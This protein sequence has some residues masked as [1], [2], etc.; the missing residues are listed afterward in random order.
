MVQRR[1]FLGLS[2]GVLSACAGRP[3]Y[4]TSRATY[5]RD[6]AMIIDAVTDATVSLAIVSADRSLLFAQR[7]AASAPAASVAKIAI[8][9]AAIDNEVDFAE[10]LDRT[11]RITDDMIVPSDVLLGSTR[12]QHN[13]ATLLYDMIVM[14]DNLAANALI[15]FIG[16][17]N[18]QN[19]LARRALRSTQ[20]TGYYSVRDSAAKQALTSASDVLAMLRYIVGG[21]RSASARSVRFKYML[22]LLVRQQDKSLIESGLPRAIELANKTGE[23]RGVLNDA[24]VIRPHDPTNAVFA[25][26]LSYGF[27]SETKTRTA[28]TQ[29]GYTLFRFLD[30]KGWL[31]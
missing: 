4:P 30:D 8:M 11:V 5:S 7:E 13:V 17:S 9:L 3:P 21:A 31:T 19:Y 1:S 24:L 29:I 12:I 28:M 25:V 27:S 23:K 22:D 18:L 26:M 16:L 20:I 15:G 6:I 2:A 14:S 10:I